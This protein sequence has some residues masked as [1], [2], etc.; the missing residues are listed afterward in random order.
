MKFS[1]LAKATQPRYGNIRMPAANDFGQKE[2]VVAT[3][4]ANKAATSMNAAPGKWSPKNSHDQAALRAKGHRPHPG[5][6]AV[7]AGSVIDCPPA[8]LQE[9]LV[10]LLDWRNLPGA[11]DD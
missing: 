7:D 2:M 10:C 5:Q 8:P 9:N 11:V 3:M 1:T 6:A 4:A